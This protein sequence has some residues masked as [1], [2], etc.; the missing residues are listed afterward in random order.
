MPPPPSCYHLLVGVIAHPQNFDGQALGNSSREYERA[1]IA[2]SLSH[3]LRWRRSIV[4]K[5]VP[6]ERQYYRDLLQWSSDHF[7]LYPYHLGDMMAVEMRTPPFLYYTEILARMITNERSYD[8][9][10]NF[11][12]ADGVNLLGVGRNQYI[13][14]MNQSKTRGLFRRRVNPRSLLPAR[15]RVPS[16]LAYWWTVAVAYVSREDVQH[17]SP[18][19]HALVDSLIDRCATACGVLDRTLVESTYTCFHGRGGGL[20]ASVGCT[21]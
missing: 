21:R 19:E 15:A 12:A 2:F 4:R 18:A 10:P 8:S 6:D 20:T 3:Q 1:V 11:S 7:M 14:I 16:H 13:D 5:F 9:L 17:C